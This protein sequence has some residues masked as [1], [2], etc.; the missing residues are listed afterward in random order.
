MAKSSRLKLSEK[1]HE[2]CTNVYFQPPTG[3]KIKYPCIIY[4]LDGINKRHADNAAYTL[5]DKYSIQYIT[6]DPDDDVKYQI[7]MMQYCSP[8]SFFV[9][10]NL[11]HYNYTIYI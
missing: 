10:E 8:G 7:A 4:D 2:L 1:L 11:Y 6:R 9:S 3:T 5:N